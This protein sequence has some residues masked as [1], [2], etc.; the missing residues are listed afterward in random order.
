MAVHPGGDHVLVGSLDVLAGVITSFF[1]M[2][3]ALCNLTCFLLEIT[4]APNFRPAF[5]SYSWKS[6]LLGFVL[7]LGVMF[8]LS[9]SSATIGLASLF[10]IFAIIWMNGPIKDWGDVS[11]A[12]IYHQVRCMG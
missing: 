7:N 11:Q 8:W 6:A 12:L 9:P 1:C 10:F 4:G 5:K 2:S 3:Y